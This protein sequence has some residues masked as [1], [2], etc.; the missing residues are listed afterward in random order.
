MTTLDVRVVDPRVAPEWQA[1][2]ERVGSS[3]FESPRWLSAIVDTYE[4]EVSARVLAA[5]DDVRAG[6][7]CVEL[8][9]FRGD[10]LVSVPFCDYLDPAVATMEE[11]RKLVDPLLAR[12]LPMQ[13]RVLRNSVPLQDDRF[14]QV[15]ELAWHGT[16]LDRDEDAIFAG[17]RA[18]ARQHVR[19]AQ[20]RGVT[21]EFGTG[22]DAVRTFYDLHRQTRKRKYRLLSQPLAFFE[23]IWKAFAPHDAIAV[24]LAHHNGE[25]IAASLYLMWNDVIYYKF[26]ASNPEYLNLRPNESLAWESMRLGRRR[27]CRAYDWGV[28]DLDQPGLVA[29]KQKFASEER[30]VT[31]LRHTPAGY[32]NPS[33]AQAGQVLGQLTELLTRADVP[34]DVTEQAG[35]TLYRYFT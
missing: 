35:D 23:N 29:Y 3:V 5:D 4:F 1:L 25:V 30:R 2:S 24:G 11:W 8:S 12:A 19:S 28:S 33:G 26:G 22:L 7:T 14:A 34:D 21:I 15:N 31:V 16:D 6:L 9:D 10:R 13:L 17:L 20:R 32:A 27:R 18:G